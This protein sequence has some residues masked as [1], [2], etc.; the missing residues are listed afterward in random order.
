MLK[1]WNVFRVGLF[2]RLRFHSV[3]GK[4]IALRNCSIFLFPWLGEAGRHS[5][6]MSV[7]Q[8]PAEPRLVGRG[9]RSGACPEGC[10]PSSCRIR[11]VPWWKSGLLPW[12]N[13]GQ[14]KPDCQRMAIYGIGSLCN[15]VGTR[16]SLNTGS[17]KPGNSEGRRYT[18]V[19]MEF[20][21]SA[22]RLRG[23]SALLMRCQFRGGLREKF[24]GGIATDSFL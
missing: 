11:N 8:K 7:R 13:A 2:Q 9:L 17:V 16:K 22:C 4:D 15:Q 23:W 12:G 24:P 20:C 21:S 1:E 18:P 3:S 5:C 10:R 14:G 6:S 19:G